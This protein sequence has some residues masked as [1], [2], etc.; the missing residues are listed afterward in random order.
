[1]LPIAPAPN[2][3]GTW[4]ALARSRSIRRKNQASTL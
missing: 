4:H 3:P 2:T 1:M